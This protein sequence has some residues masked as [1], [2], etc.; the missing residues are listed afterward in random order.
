MIC[1]QCHTEV[2]DDLIFCTDCGAR[3]F[4]PKTEEPIVFAPDARRT[5][6]ESDNPPTVLRTEPIYTPAANAKPPG[7]SSNLKWLALIVALIAIP[8]SIFGIL[9]L[10]SR[11][12]QVAQNAAPT[13]TPTVAPSRRA[14]T[15]RNAN[16]NAVNSNVNRA[17]ANANAN[18]KREKNEIMNE[19]IE[20]A[21]KTHYAREFEVSDETAR[22][23]G[24]VKITSG[25]KID[26]YVY[27][28]KNFDEFFPDET[29]KVFSFGTSTTTE[30]RQTLVA[31]DYVLVFV[32]NTDKTVV[33]EGDFSLEN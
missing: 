7:S 2:A 15:N 28:K 12:R 16:V 19:R 32:N 22:L 21:P 6:G 24:S 5:G 30:V 33:V 18:A 3:L 14:N 17:N 23:T 13:K 20:I 1:Q 8:I 25:E 11:N 29:Y 27:L 10:Q 26:G 31:E 4:E 9:L